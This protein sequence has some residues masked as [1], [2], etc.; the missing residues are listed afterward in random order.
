MYQVEQ[1]RQDLRKQLAA[2]KQQCRTLLQQITA[3]RQEQQHHVT[4]DGG[5]ISGTVWRQCDHEVLGQLAMAALTDLW[6]CECV[7]PQEKL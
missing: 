7:L 6:V 5:K 1:E 4:L 3:L 2:Q